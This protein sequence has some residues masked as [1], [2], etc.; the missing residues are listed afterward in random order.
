[1][2]IKPV[3]K[4]SLKNITGPGRP[5]E[6]R[7]IELC[8]CIEEAKQNS[9]DYFEIPLAEDEIGDTF[10][11]FTVRARNA[12][13]KMGVKVSVCTVRDDKHSGLIKIV[14]GD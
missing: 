6:K 8:K 2:D 4:Q 10:Y 12:A 7:T 9:V 3:D 14:G 13:K 1:M 5:M 11:R